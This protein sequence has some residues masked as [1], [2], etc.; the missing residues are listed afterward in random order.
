MADIKP[1]E[2]GITVEEFLK[3]L[4]NNFGDLNTTKQSKIYIIKTGQSEIDGNEKE[5]QIGTD[6][7]P[8]GGSDGDI[9]I[10]YE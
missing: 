5:I 2:A 10:V 4:N 3:Q 9:V 1:V 6:G 8:T 7:T